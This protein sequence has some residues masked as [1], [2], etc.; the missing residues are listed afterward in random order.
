MAAFPVGLPHGVPPAMG[1][2]AAAR[3]RY[4]LM[5][6][7]E[8]MNFRAADFGMDVME[9][10]DIDLMEHEELEFDRVPLQQP[11]RE[12]PTHRRVSLSEAFGGNRITWGVPAPM[13]QTQK[14]IL[15]QLPPPPMVP[16]WTPAVSEDVGRGA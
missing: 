3:R 15:P 13:Q 6:Y 12:Q 11:I 14:V 4:V 1:P 2:Q 7:L 5:Q 9:G 10:E 16:M 8:R